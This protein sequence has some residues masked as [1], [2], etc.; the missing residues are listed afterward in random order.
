MAMIILKMIAIIA[1]LVARTE[2]RKALCE[3]SSFSSSRSSD[4]ARCSEDSFLSNESSY[5]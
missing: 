5:S 1:I 4:L 3:I 2:L